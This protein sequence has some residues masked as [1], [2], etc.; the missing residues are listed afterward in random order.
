MVY[1]NYIN[2]KWLSSDSKKTFDSLNPATEQGVGK[3]QKSD[4]ID[5]KKAIKSAKKAFPVW[6][7]MPAPERAKY[8]WKIRDCLI[9]EKERLAKIEVKEMGK[10][11]KETRGDVQEAIDI[12]EYMAGE[13]R[14]LFGYTT[15]SE[16]PDK[17]AMTVRNPVGVC[18]LITPWNFPIAIPAWKIAPALICGNT[19][20]FKPSS[21]T[22]LC[23]I[24]LAKIIEKSGLPKGV[25]NLVTGS[26]KDVGDEM[27]TNP[28]VRAISF[29]GSKKIGELILKKAGIKKVGLEL[30]GKNVIIVDKDVDLELAVEGVIWGAFG[31]TGQRCTASSRVVVHKNIKKKF[32]DMLVK[33]VR[34][35]KL[36]S[37]L[38]ADIGP[39]I[40]ETAVKKSASYVSIGKEEG[41]RLLHGGKARKIKGK[42]YFFEPTIFT[43]CK[44]EMKICQ[45]EIFGPIV[46]IIE[47]KNMDEATKIAND[48]DYGLSNAVYTRDMKTAFDVINKGET[49]ITYINSSTIGAEVHLPFG[50]VKGTGNG[51]REAGIEGINEFSETKA[52]YF[53]YSGKLQKAQG[54]E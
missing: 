10:V 12:F 7:D 25:F 9:K 44:S 43:N 17:F 40:N 24:E 38:T 29:T 5:V 14:R 39:L 37:G 3:F 16:L 26:G 34:K 36:G 11:L 13:G 30:G 28:D 42:G 49:G 35:L 54:I 6:R 53:D 32:E 52:V 33:R 50:G 15:K 4:K 19:I 2:G 27:I 41:S 31:T 21:D 47:A 8:L 46:S 20:V 22:P 23:A 48:V 18:C 45:E 1:K 51:T